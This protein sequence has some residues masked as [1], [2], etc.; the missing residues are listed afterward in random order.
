M[1][2]K[3]TTATSSSSKQLDMAPMTSS[4]LEISA[5]SPVVLAAPIPLRTQTITVM[6]V[7]VGKAST[8]G[9]KI[10]PSWRSTTTNTK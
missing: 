4:R 9:N 5:P 10:G 1:T 7:K 3:V 8:A 2:G 6:T